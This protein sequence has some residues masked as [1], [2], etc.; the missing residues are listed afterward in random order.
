MRTSFSSKKINNNFP[1]FFCYLNS[2][3]VRIFANI[4]ETL[5]SS[6]SEELDLGIGTLLDS[7]LLNYKPKKKEQKTALKRLMEIA[8]NHHV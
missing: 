2:A 4:Y 6:S 1:I 8:H 5:S 3:F 7:A